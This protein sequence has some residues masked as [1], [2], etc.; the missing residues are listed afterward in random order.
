MLHF[1]INGIIRT[2]NITTNIKNNG[3]ILCFERT[4]ANDQSRRYARTAMF[5]NKITR[6]IN[7]TTNI[8]ITDRALF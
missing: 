2:L 3:E 4:S 6:T 7:F 1:V 5:I 8:G